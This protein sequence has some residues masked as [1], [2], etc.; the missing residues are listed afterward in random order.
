VM[1]FSVIRAPFYHPSQAGRVLGNQ[2]W[3]LGYPKDSKNTCFG[4]SLMEVSQVVSKDISPQ[5][6][7]DIDKHIFA[8]MMLFFNMCHAASRSP[9]LLINIPGMWPLN[10]PLQ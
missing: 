1:L 4:G 10:K 8:G 5:I 9:W 2:G 6:I 7:G 3:C